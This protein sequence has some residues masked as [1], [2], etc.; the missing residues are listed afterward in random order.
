MRVGNFVIRLIVF[1]IGIPL[2][3]AAVLAVPE[4]HHPIYL[5]VALVAAIL[6]AG[7]AATLFDLDKAGYR[8]RK[9][10]V[11]LL[12]V[13]IPLATVLEIF[14][15]LPANTIVGTLV[16]AFGLLLTGHVGRRDNAGIH[17]II[18]SVAGHAMVLL[19]PGLFISYAMR[20]ATL[21]QSGAL[22]LVYLA[23]VFFNDTM[24]YIAGRLF[25]RH[26]EGVVAIS[27]N[28]SAAGFIGG[29]VTS[30]ITIVVAELLVPGLFPGNPGKRIVFGIA[31]GV[32]V[33]VGDLVESGFKRSA[34]VKDSGNVIPGRGGM[35]DSIDSP[36]FVAP[37]FYYLYLVLF[38]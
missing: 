10:V 18:P 23:S 32:A 38:L 4:P 13:A 20:I 37:L 27:P 28:K 31:I 26:T 30:P 29:L 2:L 21:P 35:L 17:R 14:G 11:V 19:Y 25:G 1:V 24:A 5:T 22:I 33:I 7:E 9:V 16:L 34:A 15:T 12:G 8:G 36:I 3:V 6:S